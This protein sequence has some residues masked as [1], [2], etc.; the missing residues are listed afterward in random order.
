MEDNDVEKEEVDDVEDEN[1][2]DDDEKDDNVADDEVEDDDVAEDEVEDD[3]VA[4]DEVED[5]DVA[6]DEV[7][8]DDVEDDDAAPQTC[9]A[10]LVRA[11]A[12]EMHMDMAQEPFMRKFTGKS[13]WIVTLS[14][15]QTGNSRNNPC[16][17]NKKSFQFP[18][19]VNCQV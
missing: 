14:V 18:F 17:G 5:D 19:E 10:R 1:V 8:E 9:A 4:E 6:E 13:A 2:E 15:V 12:V 7:E 11:C 16:N 3:D